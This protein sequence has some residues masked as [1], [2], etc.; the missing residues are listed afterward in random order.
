M[1][2]IQERF[3]KIQPTY[4]NFTSTYSNFS[5]MNIPQL[6]CRFGYQKIYAKLFIFYINT[7]QIQS[8]KNRVTLK[9]NKLLTNR[10]KIKV[11]IILKE[12]HKTSK[13]NQ[14]W[15]IFEQCFANTNLLPSNSSLCYRQSIKDRTTCKSY[16]FGSFNQICDSKK[17]GFFPPPD[18]GTGRWSCPLLTASNFSQCCSPKKWQHVILSNF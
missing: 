9:K 14:L 10:N 16:E 4:M 3:L 11:E 17:H 12:F 15:K 5:K 8:E 18:Q 7:F 2:I 6:R 13:N 1:N